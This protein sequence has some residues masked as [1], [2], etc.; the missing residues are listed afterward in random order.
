MREF[1]FNHPIIYLF[2]VVLIGAIMLKA[3]EFIFNKCVNYYNKPLP[4]RTRVSY[5]HWIRERVNFE[6]CVR[7]MM[8]KDIPE[9]IEMTTQSFAGKYP[10][11]YFETLEEE[12]SASFKQDWWGRPKYFVFEYN[13]EILGMGGYQLSPLDWGI[14]DFFWHCVKVGWEKKGIGT[15]IVERREKEIVKQ[16]RFKA[17]VTI[18]FSCKKDVI[19]YHKKHDYKVLLK[20]AAGKEVIMGKTFKKDEN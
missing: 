17:D 5:Y 16:H 6:Q 9:C 19:K 15:A 10:K 3:L 8:E 14:Y 11:E 18:I 20:K 7:P 12:F 2:L 1:E 13:N 4:T